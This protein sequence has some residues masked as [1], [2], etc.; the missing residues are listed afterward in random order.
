MQMTQVQVSE[1]GSSPITTVPSRGTKRS[2]IQASGDPGRRQCTFCDYRVRDAWQLKQHLAD[3]HNIGVVWNFCPHCEH[4]AKHASQLKQHMADVHS[5]GVVWHYCDICKHKTK[6]A[7]ALKRHKANVHGVDLVWHF[8]DRCNQKFKQ[9]GTLKTHKARVHGIGVVVWHKCD[10][11]NH[12][13]KSAQELKRHKAWIHEVDVVWHQCKLCNFK[14]KRIWDLKKHEASLHD[15]DVCWYDC[16]QCDYKAKSK[17]HVQVHKARAHGIGLVWH[18]CDVCGHLAKSA[19]ELKTHR[20]HMHEI[21][22]VWH[23][24]DLCEYKAKRAEHLKRHVADVHDINVTWT[25]CDLC[26]Y[27]TKDKSRLQRHMSRNHNSEY[28]ARKRQQEE[29]VRKALI[30]SGYEEWTH[31]EALPPIGMFKREKKID[32]VCA[33]IDSG[34]KF[35]KIDFWISTPTGHVLLEVDE[36]QHKCGYDAELS[37]D[38]KR[39]SHVLE[40]IAIEFGCSGAAPNVFWL[41]YNPHA[42]R[43]DGELQKVPKISREDGL[44]KWLSNFKLEVPL[45]IGYACYDSKDGVLDVL[46]NPNFNSHYA[47]VTEI[48]LLT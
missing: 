18:T 17:G 30:A 8:C 46:T 1:T 48:V 7:V 11:C 10:I 42:W 37:C 13:A 35:A 38:M 47:Q 6:T 9:A 29:R 33:N 25:Q 28:I 16:D 5:I 31:T 39:M 44:M 32:F 22:V 43:I 14:T 15:I 24:C 23:K 2:R 45:K 34:A 20:A 4:K 41:R 40:S 27:K 26:D 21:G 19:Q 12:A 3:A 36:N